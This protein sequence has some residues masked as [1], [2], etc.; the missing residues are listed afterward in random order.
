MYVC[1]CV[2]IPAGHRE[3]GY[4]FGPYN[5]YILDQFSRY[6]SLCSFVFL[7]L[8]PSTSLSLFLSVPISN[9]KY[10]CI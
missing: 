7:S 6:L 5:V 3:T 9:I 2:F 1:M 10:I 4:M 8:C